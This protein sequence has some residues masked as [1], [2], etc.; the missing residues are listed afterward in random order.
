MILIRGPAANRVGLKPVPLD[1]DPRVLVT[2]RLVYR[3]GLIR[4]AD[5]GSDGV[6]PSIPLR[7]GI[8][9]MRPSTLNYSTRRPMLGKLSL[10]KF[11]ELDPGFSIIVCT[12]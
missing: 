5:L 10:K 2:Y 9:L 12:A 8:F 4:A 6:D 3:V 11:Y 1:R 7:S